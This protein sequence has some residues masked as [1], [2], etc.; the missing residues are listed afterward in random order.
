VICAIAG[1]GKVVAIGAT[2]GERAGGAAVAVKGGKEVQLGTDP[3]LSFIL[4]RDFS[5]KPQ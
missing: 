4:S 2:V 1:G 3:M 5:I